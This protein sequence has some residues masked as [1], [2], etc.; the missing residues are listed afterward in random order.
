MT[1]TSPRPSWR[2]ARSRPN[3]GDPLDYGR[4]RLGDLALLERG[5]VEPLADLAELARLQQKVG[6]ARP[7]EPFVAD[8]ERLVDQHPARRQRTDDI[9][10]DRPEQIIG[11]DDPVVTAAE[12]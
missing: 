11:H 2:P 6:V 1:A 3:S 5:D 12:R 8:R 4:A 7:A 10:Q 9:R